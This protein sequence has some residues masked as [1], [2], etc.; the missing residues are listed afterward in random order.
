MGVRTGKLEKQWDIT[1]IVVNDIVPTEGQIEQTRQVGEWVGTTQEIGGSDEVDAEGGR[2]ETFIVERTAD[3][4][5]AIIGHGGQEEAFRGQEQAE[6][7]ALE[8]ATTVGNNFL[9]CD[10][11]HQQLRN[12]DWGIAEIQES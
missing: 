3:G 8:E 2:H 9:S 1:E 10:I 12:E 11:V 5:V 6:K 7:A 4:K